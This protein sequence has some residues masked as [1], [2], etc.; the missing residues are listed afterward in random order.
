VTEPLA[1]I[2]GITVLLEQPEGYHIEPIGGAYVLMTYIQSLLPNEVRLKSLE[3]P[4]VNGIWAATIELPWHWS[5][6]DDTDELVVRCR[7]AFKK[8]LR[9]VE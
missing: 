1:W 5:C 8:A 7:H 4:A 3:G 9:E 2:G 6:W